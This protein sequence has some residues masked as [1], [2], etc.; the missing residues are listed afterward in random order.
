VLSEVIFYK[1]N[2]NDCFVTVVIVLLT[3]YNSIH[4]V[5]LVLSE[6]LSWYINI[7]YIHVMQIGIF[8]F[9]KK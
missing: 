4:M 2:V 9:T 3:F 7:M 8:T 1:Y 5:S 6:V